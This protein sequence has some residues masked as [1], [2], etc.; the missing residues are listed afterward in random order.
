MISEKPYNE[1]LSTISSSDEELNFIFVKGI[2]EQNTFV[3]T[4]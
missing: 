2:R 3:N 1:V 4:N